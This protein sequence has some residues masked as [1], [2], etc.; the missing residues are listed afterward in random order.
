MKIIGITGG[1]GS[2]KTTVGK[3]FESFGAEV[4]DADEISREVTKKDGAAY[5]EIVSFFG[6]EILLADKELNRKAISDIVFKD[7]KSLEMLNK[8][9]HKHIFLKMEEQY[10]PGRLQNLVRYGIILA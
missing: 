10:F 1:I 8:I 6:D 3:M 2:G 9:T 5:A 7:K 4:I